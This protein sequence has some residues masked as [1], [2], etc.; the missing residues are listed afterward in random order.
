[1][2]VHDGIISALSNNQF[3]QELK[4]VKPCV[5]W[6]FYRHEHQH[7]EMSPVEISQLKTKDK[8][9]PIHALSEELLH[10]QYGKDPRH[11]QYRLSA[12]WK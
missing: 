5:N 9:G 3:I 1:M 2:D 12:I 6:L 4:K 11:H 10:A 7:K 8:D